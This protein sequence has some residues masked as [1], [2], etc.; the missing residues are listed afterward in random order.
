MTNAT[1]I[2]TAPAKATAS[3]RHDPPVAVSQATASRARKIAPGASNPTLTT[4]GAPTPA[5][6]ITHG[7]TR[8]L[9]AS[10]AHGT[11]ATASTPTRPAETPPVTNTSSAAASAANGNARPVVRPP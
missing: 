10:I 3:A 2:A 5:T 6:I 1:G 4:A 11:S 7:P 8:T 9:P